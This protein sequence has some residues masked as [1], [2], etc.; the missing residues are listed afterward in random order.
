MFLIAIEIIVASK[1]AENSVRE[2][3][4]EKKEEMGKKHPKSS[5]RSIP[6]EY[7]GRINLFKLLFPFGKTFTFYSKKYKYH[8][9]IEIFS[10]TINP[11]WRCPL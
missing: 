11:F 10:E 3:D 7:G 6:L 2:S 4:D 5:L 8:L 9:C 1:K